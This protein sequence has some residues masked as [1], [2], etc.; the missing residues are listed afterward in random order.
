[1]FYCGK[2]IYY[3]LG[4]VVHILR[5]S[6]PSLLGNKFSGEL[7]AY[8]DAQLSLQESVASGNDTA[9]AFEYEALSPYNGD[10]E[11]ALAGMTEVAL[12]GFQQKQGYVK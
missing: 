3:D 2:V 6:L 12:A 11:F 1:M 5:V 4:C 9:T 10:E 7:K 8:W